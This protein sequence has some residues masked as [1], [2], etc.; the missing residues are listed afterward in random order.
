MLVLV[1][2]QDDGFD[3]GIAFH[4]DTLHRSGSLLVFGGGYDVDVGE[5]IGWTLPLTA[6]GMLDGR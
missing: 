2:L 5:D 6:F 4:Q 3:G 1:D